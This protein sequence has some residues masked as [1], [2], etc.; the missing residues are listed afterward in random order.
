MKSRKQKVILFIA[1]IIAI[2]L[3]LPLSI[4][5]ISYIFNS[6]V[7]AEGGSIPTTT[8]SIGLALLASALGALTLFLT[9]R[10]GTAKDEV[11]ILDQRQV[12]HI[13]KCYLLAALCF[14]IFA[15]LS[16]L[17]PLDD[18]NLNFWDNVVK[19]A[20]AISIIAGSVSLAVAVIFSMVFI[21][22]WRM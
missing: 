18:N 15:L 19:W 21:W 8:A 4:G 13:G 3:F 17:L 20:S 9:S 12:G 16:P 1:I 11:G 6:D 14:T 5:A 10:I 22:F 2:I 7:D